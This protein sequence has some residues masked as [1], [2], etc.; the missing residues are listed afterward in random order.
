MPGFWRKCRITFRWA[1]LCVWLL[2][3]AAIGAFLWCNRVG[4]PDFLKARVVATL[5]E[6]GVGLEFS[7]MRLS[8]VR[9]IVAENVR[10]GTGPTAGGAAQWHFWRLRLSPAN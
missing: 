4:L 9:G 7:R 5:R 8:L 10:A 6:R 3:L 2:V 1:R